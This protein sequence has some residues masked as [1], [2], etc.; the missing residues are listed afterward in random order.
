MN[1]ELVVI[2]KTTQHFTQEALQMYSKR[3]EHYAKFSICEIKKVKTSPKTKPEVIR[4]KEAIL[5]QKHLDKTNNF[6]V[7]LDERGKRM[8]SLK[9][10]DFIQKQQTGGTQNLKFIIGGAFGFSPKIKQQANLLLSF[11][12]MTFSHQIIRLFFAEQLYRA[13]TIINNEQYHNE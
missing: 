4:E 9:F 6:T 3:I 5:L 10:A 1:I 2:G 7:L 8:T 13:F 11:S 12:D